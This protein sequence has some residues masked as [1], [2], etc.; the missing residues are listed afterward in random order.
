MVTFFIFKM[1]P[2]MFDV[3][4][5]PLDVFDYV[6]LDFVYTRHQL[7][8]RIS[9]PPKKFW[10][11]FFA[12]HKFLDKTIFRPGLNIAAEI[13]IFLHFLLVIL[14]LDLFHKALPSF[15]T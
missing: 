9:A 13:I 11:L 5:L 12:P 14:H 1:M 3:L 7:S 6:R 8:S 2:L 4:F 15:K 10:R